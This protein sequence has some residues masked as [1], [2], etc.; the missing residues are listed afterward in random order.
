[1]LQRRSTPPNPF[2]TNYSQSVGGHRPPLQDIPARDCESAGRLYVIQRQSRK[3]DVRCGY[4]PEDVNDHASQAR[5]PCLP[6]DPFPRDAVWGA[7]KTAAEGEETI[8]M[9]KCRVP[10]SAKYCRLHVRQRDRWR[11]TRWVDEEHGDI[12]G[13]TREGP[14]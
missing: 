5:R 13:R 6:L 7:K 12:E 10:A 8:R 4:F 11:I 2:V 14:L 9:S 3:E 1:N